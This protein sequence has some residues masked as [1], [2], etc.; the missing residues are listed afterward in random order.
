MLYATDCN[1][2]NIVVRY[3]AIMERSKLMSLKKLSLFQYFDIDGFLAKKKLMTVGIGEWK[4]F[5][6][7]SILGTKVEVVIVA[8][9]TD[10]GNTDGNVANNLY[11]KLSVKIPAKLNNVP[12]NAIVRLINPEAVVYGEYRNA[13]S[14]TAESIEIVGK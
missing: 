7:Q 2:N 11:E 5:Q 9:E 13:L 6:T 14:I 4:N 3:Q 1:W 10:Y 12:M 8:D